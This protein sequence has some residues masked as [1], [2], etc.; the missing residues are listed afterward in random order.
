MAKKAIFLGLAT[1]YG[2]N[3]VQNGVSGVQWCSPRGYSRTTPNILSKSNNIFTEIYWF[4]DFQNGVSLIRTM[5]WLKRHHYDIIT[6]EYLVCYCSRPIY[7]LHSDTVSGKIEPL[8]IL[9]SSSRMRVMNH[10]W[11]ATKQ[12]LHPLSVAVISRHSVLTYTVVD[13]RHRFICY[14]QVYRRRYES[15]LSS[16]PKLH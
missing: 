13:G 5:F 11:S 10:N 7:V 8:D 2:L 9:R 6:Q 15:R 14:R 3:V 4:N 1:N 16:K 12:R